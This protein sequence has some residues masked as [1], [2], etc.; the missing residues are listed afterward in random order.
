MLRKPKEQARKG[1][2]ALSQ[3]HTCAD[4]TVNRV[5]SWGR[6]RQPR[7]STPGPVWKPAAAPSEARSGGK[8]T[9][10]EGLAESGGP[11]ADERQSPLLRHSAIGRP[12][13]SRLGVG[14]K[15]EQIDLCAGNVDVFACE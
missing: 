7:S 2:C 4:D 11:G 3:G 10:L 8:N 5:A 14:A 6:G 13:G 15:E 1:K 9:Q 12:T